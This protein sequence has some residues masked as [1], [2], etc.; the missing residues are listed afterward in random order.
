MHPISFC[1]HRDCKIST[2]NHTLL[3]GTR[4]S[5]WPRS[6]VRPTLQHKRQAVFHHSINSICWIKPQ[7][8]RSDK[9]RRECDSLVELD[10]INLPG[11]RKKILDVVL[12]G[13]GRHI[14]D[15]YCVDR[16]LR[17]IPPS[18]TPT[19]PN[20]PTTSSRSIANRQPKIS[21]PRQIT[22][23]RNTTNTATP[24]RIETT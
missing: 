1:K 5:K 10:V 4:M 8:T 24:S 13:F 12:G 20:H 18:P 23:T 11:K 3:D 22:N 14:T 9:K 7:P 6:T 17:L 19:Q 16:P 2:S 21:Q 15:S